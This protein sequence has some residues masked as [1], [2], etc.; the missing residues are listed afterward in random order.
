MRTQLSTTKRKR[1]R[2]RTFALWLVVAGMLSAGS[3]VF[4]TTGGFTARPCPA[5]RILADPPPG[6]DLRRDGMNA[7]AWTL[8]NAQSDR[9]PAELYEG[10]PVEPP[11]PVLL[12]PPRLFVVATIIGSAIGLV[13]LLRESPDPGRSTGEVRSKNPTGA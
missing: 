3:L 10:L 6:W 12:Y 9:A 1:T 13:A 5:D 8:F 11:N 2:G 7:C 4:L